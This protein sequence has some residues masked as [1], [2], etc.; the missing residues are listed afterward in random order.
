MNN[1]VLLS[2]LKCNIEILT[3]WLQAVTSPDTTASTVATFPL[4]QP[5]DT[6]CRLSLPTG[7]R[8]TS[9]HL[10]LRKLLAIW[11]QGSILAGSD[12]LWP[13]DMVS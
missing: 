11:G 13:M 7:T 3:F 5:A 10:R 6:P 9:S 12:G 2:H 4:C 1:F 8:P